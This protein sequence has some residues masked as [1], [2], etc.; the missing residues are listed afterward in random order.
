MRVRFTDTALTQLAEILAHIS[1]E[2]PPA[3]DR[4]GVR[5]RQVI[6]R[7]RNFPLSARET[8][9]PGVRIAPAIIDRDELGIRNIR[10]GAREGP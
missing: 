2:N 8:E 6:E 10:H 4:V 7:L 9:Q 1:Q 3:A 5:I